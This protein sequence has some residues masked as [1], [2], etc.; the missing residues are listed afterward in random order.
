M[1]DKTVVCVTSECEFKLNGASAMEAQGQRIAHHGNH[2]IFA[3]Y[4]KALEHEAMKP[5]A[6]LKVTTA[7]N[8]PIIS[9][10]PYTRGNTVW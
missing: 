8:P 1:R 3:N 6:S 9:W 7:L 4:K 5:S 10:A 2:L